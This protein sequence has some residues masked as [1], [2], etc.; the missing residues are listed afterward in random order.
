MTPGVVPRRHRSRKSG[1]LKLLVALLSVCPLAA[2][3]PSALARLLVT[4]TDEN[5]VVVAGAQVVL[6]S[7]QVFVRCETDAGGRCRFSAPPGSYELSASKDGFYQL[8]VAEVRVGETANL[9][10]TLAHQQE[11]QETVNVTESVPAIDPAQAASSAGLNGREI[12]D[13]P[14]PTTRDIRNALPLIP[15]VVR[16][17]S[18]QAHVAGSDSSQTLDLLDGFDITNPVTGTLDLR[19]SPDAVRA[20]D[21]ESSRYSVAHGRASGGVVGFDTSM[22]DDHFRFNATNFVP[23]V[24]TK[25]GLGFD[26]WTPRATLS[27]PLK[28]GKAWFLLAPE[29][30]YDNNLYTDLPDGADRNPVLRGSL[31]AKMQVNASAH[32]IFSGSFLLGRMYSEY[33]GISLVNPQEA[34]QNLSDRSY[35]GDIREQHYFTGGGVLEVG[36]AA[37]SYLD[38][39]DPQGAAP[40]VIHPDRNT[41]NYFLT[42]AALSG[43]LEGRISYHLPPLR[44]WGRHDLLAGSDVQSLNYRQQDTRRPFSITREDG[45][46]LSA[47]SFQTP[48]QF[49]EDNLSG[50]AYLEDN[51]SPQEHVL[52]QPGV[53]WDRDRIIGRNLVS[54]RL[55]AT[56]MLAAETKLSAG[57][58]IYYDAT[59]LDLVS[60]PLAG[61]RLQTFYAADG[62]TPLGPAAPTSFHLDPSALREPHMLNWSLALEQELPAKIFLRAEYMRKRGSDEFSYVNLS[63]NLFAGDY[64]LRNSRQDRID[65]FQI[66]ARRTFKDDHVVMASYTR[67]AARSNAVL[68]FTLDSPFF[69]AQGGGPL[70]WDSPNRLLAWGFLPVP[71]TKRWS[72]AY[73]ADWRTGFPFNVVNQYQELVGSPDS[74]RF[75]DYLSIDLFA[76]VRFGAIGHN[77]ALRG[78][79]EDLN[80]RKNPMAVNNNVDSPDFLE[81]SVVAHRAF[82]ARIRFL[83][84]K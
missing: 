61:A 39:A 34:T 69:G 19:F 82:T 13:I 62:V 53:R 1:L 79:F 4:I 6:D 47:V 29:F 23:S 9:D 31:L 7:G 18:G 56:Y 35:L 44:F 71:H 52:I 12:I 58:G 41:G 72:F 77:W 48:P 45:S 76:E 54:P 46:L 68:D 28:K 17:N 32:D 78:G 63:P 42:S 57:V 2:Q 67:S 49:T 73:V 14:F 20:I 81:Y 8:H 66:D 24:Q 43:R 59:N 3:N 33:S 65:S 84:R 22:G 36:M 74:R 25:K 37:S 83:G 16:D 60:R 11:V 51:W 50:A 26:A 64:W 55:S 38:H 30:E 10:L 75:P 21:V 27:G 70:P 15:G 5:G 40:Y 80:N